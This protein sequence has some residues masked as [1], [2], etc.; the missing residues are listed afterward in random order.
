MSD[1]E[2]DFEFV[3]PMF[4]HSGEATH[5]VSERRTRASSFATFKM[6]VAD[7]VKGTN[8]ELIPSGSVMITVLKG[9]NLPK[10][11]SKSISLSSK[12]NDVIVRFACKGISVSTPSRACTGGSNPLWDPKKSEL[13]LMVYGDIKKWEDNFE[14]QI[15]VDLRNAKDQFIATGLLVEVNMLTSKPTKRVV[16]LF[17]VE[18]QNPLGQ[19][20]IMISF[21]K[22][23]LQEKATSFSENAFEKQRMIMR[24]FK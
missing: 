15:Q 20:E 9:S 7:A 18:M 6:A 13:A 12:K 22:A 19:L 4:S 24:N 2:E 23:T 3:N 5:P 14:E 8:S 10:V 1:D 21:K 16:E 11:T 17:D